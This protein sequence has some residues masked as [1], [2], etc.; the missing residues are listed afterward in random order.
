[1]HKSDCSEYAIDRQQL[2]QQLIQQWLEGVKGV[3]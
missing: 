2:V 3:R 1:M